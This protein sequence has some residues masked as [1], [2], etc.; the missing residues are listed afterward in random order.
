MKIVGLTKNQA[1]NKPNSVLPAAASAKAGLARFNAKLRQ[2]NG[3]HL[4]GP[5]I[6]FRPQASYFFPPKF[7]SLSS[8]QKFGRVALALS[9]NLAVS[10]P[11]CAGIHPA[12]LLARESRAFR[13]GRHCSHPFL[14]PAK[15]G[16]RMAALNRWN[17]SPADG[18][19]ESSDFPPPINRNLQEAIA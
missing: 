8:G 13:P 7:L 16:T 9:R 18:G 10:L 4:S 2:G 1:G 14:R 6:A 5:K 19:R 12:R 3:N 17:L 11:A 15:R